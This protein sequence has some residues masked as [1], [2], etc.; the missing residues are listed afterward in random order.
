MGWN[1]PKRH[2]RPLKCKYIDHVTA[3]LSQVR[4]TSAED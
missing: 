2:L 3:D 1:H 4:H